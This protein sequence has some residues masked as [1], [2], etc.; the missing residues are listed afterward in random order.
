MGLTHDARLDRI[1]AYY[2]CAPR[3]VAT[4]EQVG[5]FTLFVADEGTGWQF[6]A[7]PRLGGG[8]TFTPDDVCRV[9]ERQRELTVPLAIE[10]VEQVTPSLLPAV[11]GAGH[12]PH[13]Y[14][15]L[16][17]PADVAVAPDPRARPLEPA[18]PHLSLAL[19]SVSAGFS[20]RDEVEPK[21]PGRHPEMMERGD[22]VVVA[23]FE[24]NR[25]CGAGSAAPRGDVAE[26]MGIAVP[27]GHRGRGHGTAIT[28]SLVA[29]AR[30]RG[31]EVVFLS[32]G[33]DAAAS[34]Y[35][36]VGFVDLG[37]ACVLGIDD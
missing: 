7:R 31:V 4:V 36:R 18:E 19:G 9:L 37:T 15:L 14:P 2:D 12:E 13:R 27:P 24:G 22:L 35:R 30:E 23:S 29:A 28:S 11:R 1:E 8:H 32:A 20:E 21:D 10:W 34:I 33:S 17:M 26:L 16:V 3:A 25:L 5:P 6:Y